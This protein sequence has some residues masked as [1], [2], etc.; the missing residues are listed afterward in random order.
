MNSYRYALVLAYN[1]TNFHG[2]QVQ[3]NAITVQ[4]K[5]KEALYILLKHKICVHGAGRTD[6]GVHASFFVAHF[7]TNN[8]IS[9]LNKFIRSLNGLLSNEIVIYDV[10]SVDKEFHSR[11][12]AVSRTYKYVI[13]TN[14]N[15]F[16]NNFSH[17]FVFDL[18]IIRMNEASEI[19][20]E[21]NDFKSFEKSH[22]D[23]K[24][25]LCD[26]KQAVWHEIDNGLVFT[27]TADRFLRNMV[28]SIV[29]TMLNI[30]Q[31]RTSVS[32][33][34]EIIESK[35]RQKAGKSADAR[36]L[37]LVDI[38]YKEPVN[39]ALIIGRKNSKF[40]FF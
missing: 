26:L 18:D 36:G 2:W 28:R 19:L 12:D 1:G 35:N 39:S 17:K 6:T 13:H 7:D 14:K 31:N 25:S 15:P 3:P 23:S 4:Q 37:Y 21:Y 40:S 32:Q 24:T 38:Q 22:S 8:E 16:I 29:G 5:I 30:G 33:F 11:F 10:V 27:I 9:D 34:R 20:M